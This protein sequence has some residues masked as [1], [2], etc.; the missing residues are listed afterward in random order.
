MDDYVGPTNETKAPTPTLAVLCDGNQARSFRCTPQSSK[1]TLGGWRSLV[2]LDCFLPPPS[3][4]PCC[5]H[6][7][8]H[9]GRPI[10]LAS[11]MLLLVFCPCNE[12]TGDIQIT[13]GQALQMSGAVVVTTP[14]KL[15][16]VDV[17]KGIDMFA[18]IKVCVCG[19]RLA[20]LC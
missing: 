20:L 14:Q 9:T 4:I 16:Y 13:L 5:S 11:A 15:S 17:V 6:S 8:S 2:P 18:E 3:A 10:L 7:Q 19:W 1:P 12:G